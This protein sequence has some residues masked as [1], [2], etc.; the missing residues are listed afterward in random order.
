M[1]RVMH[2][3][4]AALT[5]TLAGLAA[6]G[7][8]THET[9]PLLRVNAI[10]AA[11]EIPQDQLLDVGVHLFD[12]NVPK[13][14]EWMKGDLRD[15]DHVEA[16]FRDRRFDYVFHLA[17]YAAEGLS[18]FIRRYNY[19]TNLVASMNLVNAAVNHEVKCFVF[20]SSIAVYGR[21]QT[22]M[23]EDMVP[24][25]EAPYGVSSYAVE[26]DL[27]AADEMFGLEYSIFR[28]H[29]VY[30]ERQ[31]VAERCRNVVGVFMNLML[32][33]EP[34]TVLGDGLQTRAFSPDALRPGEEVI[35]TAI[36]LYHIFALTVNFLSYFAA[37]AE[38]WRVVNTRDPD[39]LID[40]LK[41]AR[42]TI[43]TGVNSL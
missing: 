35:V 12:E 27:R 4:A 34:L 20:T 23:T 18:H 8:M 21:G 11:A 3:I 9:R 26:L 13:D 7:C 22:P 10:Q 24:E 30:G 36:P 19:Q 17:A 15:P 14:A 6:G 25:P 40:V 33:G 39:A 1:N 42:P 38:N 16:L 43:V 32:M 29:N 2:R 41:A 28:P 5:V 31:N 37:G